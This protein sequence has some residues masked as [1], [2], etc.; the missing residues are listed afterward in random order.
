VSFTSN[1]T[2]A[3]HHAIRSVGFTPVGQVLGSCVYSIGWTGSWNC[4]IGYGWGGSRRWTGSA[5]GPS[6]SGGSTGG[7]G[8]GAGIVARTVEATG[9]RDSLYAA[10]G[11][12]MQRM[13]A[14]AA[15]VGGDGVVAVRLT[16]APFES[17]GLEFRAVGTAVRADGEVRPRRP[18]TSDL[19][20]E[21]FGQLIAA[22]WVPA[23]ML[24]GIAVMV[25]HDDWRTR[26]QLGSWSWTNQE[27]DGYTDVTAKARAGARSRLAADTARYGDGA[28]AVVRDMSLRIRRRSCAAGNE[29]HDHLA[30]AMVVGTAIVPF[31]H[32]GGNAPA[33]PLPVL[34]LSGRT[35]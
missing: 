14:E 20:G 23:G 26:S 31:G 29:A 27:V 2:V 6:W 35:P 28:T 21:E 33:P 15:R 5:G 4:G 12:A 19:S 9:L 11:A 7:Y 18:F 17:A 16:V 34:R 22:G 1:L 25:R 10:R 13:Q 8:L 3:E 30:E 32:R 24:L